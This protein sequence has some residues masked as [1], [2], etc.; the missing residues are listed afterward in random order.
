MHTCPFILLLTTTNYY[1]Y[2]PPVGTVGFTILMVV[3]CFLLPKRPELCL[4]TR[5]RMRMAISTNNTTIHL[6]DDDGWMVRDG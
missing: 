3:L 1:Y 2:A 5:R 6:I 4:R